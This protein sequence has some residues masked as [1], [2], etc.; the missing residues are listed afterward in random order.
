MISGQCP[1]FF[2]YFHYD[3]IIYNLQTELYNEWSPIYST[4]NKGKKKKEY[5]ESSK[6]VYLNIL[7][8]VMTK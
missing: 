8:R 7:L 3:S 1:Q 6:N 2:H 5:M 4:W